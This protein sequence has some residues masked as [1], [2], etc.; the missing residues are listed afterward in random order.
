MFLQLIRMPL[1]NQIF[2]ISRF[3]LQNA[4]HIHIYILMSLSMSLLDL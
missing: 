1:P 2:E 4:A 3:W